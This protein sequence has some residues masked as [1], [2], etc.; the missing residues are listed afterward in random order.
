MCMRDIRLFAALNDFITL[1][2]QGGICDSRHESRRLTN[3][4]AGLRAKLMANELADG[5]FINSIVFLEELI[6]FCVADAQLCASSIG[7]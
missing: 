5:H 6:H 7:E 1:C 2:L 4:R 3:P